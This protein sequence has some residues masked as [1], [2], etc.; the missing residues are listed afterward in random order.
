ME[1]FGYPIWVVALICVG[2]F[3]AAFVDAI[4]GGGGLISLPVYVMAGLPYH[5]ALGT[6]KL[7]A[8]IGT[9]VS[10]AR[11]VK[12]G[13][14]NWRLASGSIVLAV[15]GAS[16]GTKLQLQVPEAYLR[17]TLLVV[18]PAVAVL[19]LSPKRQLP[20]EP[21]QIGA[22]LQMGIV[23]GS[24]LLVGI[25]DG[26]YGP[27][28]GTFLLL[29]FCFFGKM[30]LRTAS[31]NV[32][33]AN[34]ASNAGSLATA[35]L[36]ETVIV[37]LGLTAAVFSVAGNYLGAGLNMKNGTKIVRPVILIVLALLVIKVVMDM[38]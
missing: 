31:G 13:F 37:P 19:M 26:F 25:Y 10:T 21:G 24:S 29:L 6:N 3:L 38:L 27:G 14:V 9:A 12:N 22:G 33:L 11:Y 30:D 20:E 36:A 17:Y 34:L 5:N 4:G 16:L 28:T 1:I 2:V 7:S 8:C 23:W 32:K 18:L 15:V 35:L